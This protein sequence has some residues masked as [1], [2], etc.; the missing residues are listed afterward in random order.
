MPGP[1]KVTMVCGTSSG[2]KARCG[3][4]VATTSGIGV[5]FGL[6]RQ[7]AEGLVEQLA[8]RVGID[9][10]DHGDPQRIL[11]DVAA[12]ILL[13]IG[14]LDGRHALERAGRRPAVGMIAESELEELAAGQ[15]GRIGRF[16]AQV[17]DDLGADAFDVLRLEPRRG[18]RHPQQ[19]VGFVLVVL[20]HAQ[21]A[22]ELIAV[23]REA[24]LDGAAFEPLMIGLGIEIAGALIEQIGRASCRERV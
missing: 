11:G 10:A 6:G 8:E 2:T 17:R 3:G 21:R 1:P 20:E 9:V 14:D 23:R 13:Q 19:I 4:L 12:D 22:A 15:R 18:Q 7:V 5:N 24:E 16:A